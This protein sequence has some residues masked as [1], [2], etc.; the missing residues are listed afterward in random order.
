MAQRRWMIRA[1]VTA[2]ACLSAAASVWAQSQAPAAAPASETAGLVD[3][4]VLPVVLFEPPLSLAAFG[5]PMALSA[6]AAT[7]GGTEVF[8][9][10]KLKGVVADNQ[11]INLATGSNVIADGAFS[12]AS[13]LPMVIQNSGNNVLIQSATI[14]NVQLQ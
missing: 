1:G 13:G 7:R 6:L 9:D 11:A 3:P 2:F 14:V 4:A 12:G 5:A 8:S 10:M